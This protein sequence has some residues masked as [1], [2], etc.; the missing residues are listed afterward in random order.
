MYNNPDLHM[1]SNCS[2]GSNSPAE[3]L[4]NVR[5]SGVDMFALTDHDTYGGCFE[6][7]KLLKPGDPKFIRGIEMSCQDDIRKYHVL[8]YCF[9]TKKDSINNAVNIT[10]NA[11]RDKALNRIKYLKDVH[12]MEFSNEDLEEL[13]KNENPGRPHFVNL[14]MRYGYI[15]TKEEGFALVAGYV[16]EEAKLTPE[17]AVDS[18]LSADGIPVL[19]HGIKG[20]G[21]K[22]FSADE[23]EGIVKRLKECGL[24]GLECFYSTY[25]P[26]QRDIM[27]D[28]ANKYNLLV[29]AGSDYHGINKPIQIGQ[30]NGVD[31]TKMQRFYRTVQMLTEE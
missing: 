5:K 9:D 24:M 11:R 4:E 17:I 13:L 6:I 27:L 23:I 28:L 25:T 10:H 3:L 14:M 22:N 18:I 2:D 16:G 8:G 30:T 29:T 1:H 19:A 21:S 12:G 7:E 15:K 20:D 26:E 31:N